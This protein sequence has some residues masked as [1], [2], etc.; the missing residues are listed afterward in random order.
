MSQHIWRRINKLLI[1]TSWL[2]RTIAQLLSIVFLGLA[3]INFLIMDLSISHEPS[4]LVLICSFMLGITL[5]IFIAMVTIDISGFVLRRLFFT[6]LSSDSK[7]R[8]EIVRTLFSLFCG[9]LLSFFGLVGV[10][11]LQI[12]P[13][14]IPIKA[15]HPSLNGTTIAQL[16]DIHLGPFIGR[17]RLKRIVDIT[18]S[19]GAD[20]V[21]ITG[22]LAD[23]PLDVMKKGVEP[24]KDL[25]TKY[26]TYFCTGTHT[27]TMYMYMYLMYSV[28]MYLMCSVYMYL[29]YSV[30]MTTCITCIVC[31]CISCIVCTCISCVV[32]TC[33]TCIVCT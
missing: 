31:T 11:N 32:C 2:V 9:I 20:I 24:L 7:R 10:N 15:L 8:E 30:Y 4:T 22:D 19:L 26:G 25:K 28:Y 3:T 33:I 6:K 16:S 17:S 29:M 18:N 27:C 1:N 14:T 21:V 23:S 13:V 12:E 5:F